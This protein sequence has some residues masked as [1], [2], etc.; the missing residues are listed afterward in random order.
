MEPWTAVGFYQGER[1]HLV[2]EARSGQGADLSAWVQIEAEHGLDALGN[3]PHEICG[4]LRGSFPQPRPL[5][6][7][8]V[9]CGRPSALA[10]RLR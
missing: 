6:W 8:R 1:W 2:V 7:G 9:R 4:V 5:P 3:L 10:G